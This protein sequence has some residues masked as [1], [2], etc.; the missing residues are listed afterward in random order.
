MDPQLPAALQ[1]ALYAASLGIVVAVLVLV[2]MALGARRQIE[3]LVGAVEELQAELRPLAQETRVVVKRLD[4]LYGRAREQ[5]TVVEGIVGTAR[6]WSDRANALVEEIGAAVRPPAL[7]ASRGLRLLWR[8]LETLLQLLVSR[9]RS[10]PRGETAGSVSAR[11]AASEPTPPME[12]EDVMSEMNHGG[13]TGAATGIAVAAL[14][15]LAVGAGV[16]LL[17]AP[18]SGRETRGW[19]A[20]QGRKLQ[21][22]AASALERGGETT[23]RV[24]KEIGTDAGVGAT[25]VRG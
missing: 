15:G 20:H 23:L 4:D 17:F 8:G 1:I 25:T 22:R 13:G 18:C 11:A 2:G 12:S 5:W 6:R 10:D 19:L 24:A 14:V 16:A 21:D 3:R 7:A 9:D